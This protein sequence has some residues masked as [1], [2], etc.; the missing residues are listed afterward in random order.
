MGGEI[1]QLMR[2]GDNDQNQLLLNFSSNR[3]AVINV[4]TN[5][6]TPFAAALTTAKATEYIAVDSSAIFLNTASAMLDLFESGQPSIDRS[7]TLTIRR[8]LDAAA[9]EAAHSEF[10]QL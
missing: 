10:V 1:Q 9:T 5:A 4:Y 2:R 6:N 8:A 7:E 3:T